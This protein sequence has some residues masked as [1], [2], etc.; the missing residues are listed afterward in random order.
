MSMP[1]SEFFTRLKWF[2]IWGILVAV[3]VLG[4]AVLQVQ[5]KH[6]GDI[7]TQT[8]EIGPHYPVA[9]VLGAGIN[10]DGTPSDMLH[11]RLVVGEELY[12][13]HKV[14]KI[15]VTGDD[16]KEFADEVTSMKTFLK[17]E[18]IPD[19]D[20]IIDE[21]GYRT[22]VSCQHAK[23]KFHI[24]SAILVTQRFHIARALYLCDAVGVDS[25]GITSDRQSYK[26]TTF[27]WMRDLAASLKA[28]FDINAGRPAGSI[29]I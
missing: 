11:D 15:M 21:G 14:D 8:T 17:T 5:T 27:Y 6:L 1:W 29:A 24:A 26:Y 2:F 28:F 3:F 20:V 16:G 19:E 10:P 13:A 23:E 7:M 9:I 25:V 22:L 18:G 12:K 4:W